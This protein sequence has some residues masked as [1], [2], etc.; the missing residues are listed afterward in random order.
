MAWVKRLYANEI[1][2]LHD[3]STGSLVGLWYHYD[4]RC[5]YPL[6][7]ILD[8][9]LMLRA[10]GVAIGSVGGHSKTRPD[11]VI[12]PTSKDINVVKVLMSNLS[13][14]YLSGRLC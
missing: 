8:F 12:I 3:C 10:V 13:R 4:C 14:K 9:L 11:G 7:F 5:A 2:T 1:L 6:L